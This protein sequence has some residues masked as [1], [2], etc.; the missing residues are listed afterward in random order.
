MRIKE[1]RKLNNEKYGK[2]VVSMDNDCLNNITQET[3]DGQ[4]LVDN[5]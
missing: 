3:E 2:R 5:K 1:D 4:P